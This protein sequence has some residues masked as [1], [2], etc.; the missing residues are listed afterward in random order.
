[1]MP[2]TAR[3]E[4]APAGAAEGSRT[5]SVRWA[6]AVLRRPVAALVGSVLLLGALSAPV[7]DLRLGFPDDTSLDEGNTRRVAFETIEE[8]FGAGF[9]APLTLAVDLRDAADVDA[10]LSVVVGRAAAVPGVVAVLDPVVN[11]SG[12][13]AIVAV[14]PSDGPAAPE[15]EAV[16]GDLRAMQDDVRDAAG[17]TVHVTG[18]TATNLDTADALGD[19]LVPFLLLVLGLMMLLLVLAFRSIVVAVKAVIAILLSVAASFGVLV[20]VFQW[21]WL[22]ELVGVEGSLP[23]IPFLPI[24]MFAILFGLSMDYEVFILSR[25]RERITAG[26]DPT[27]AALHGLGRSAKVI[28]AAALIMIAVF[29]SFIAQPDPTIKMFGVGLAVAVLLDATVVRMV[30]VPAALAL[31]G[32]RA[33][34]LPPR[35]DRVL[36]DLDIEGHRLAPPTDDVGHGERPE[37]QLVESSSAR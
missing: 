32:A 21:G 4:V 23:L 16:L 26:D 24:I 7:L 12:D 28:S 31:L 20:A 17:A 14:V 36:P 2:R 25:V 15:T 27:A 22:A 11:A 3:V 10:A 37:A 30:F 5:L 18:L 9:N 1:V 8:A 13:T 35:L 34:R 19:A 33:W 29:G 6:T